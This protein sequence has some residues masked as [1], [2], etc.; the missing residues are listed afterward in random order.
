MRFP[1][2]PNCLHE[3]TT[4]ANAELHFLLTLNFQLFSK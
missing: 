3:F 1:E 2:V 4:T